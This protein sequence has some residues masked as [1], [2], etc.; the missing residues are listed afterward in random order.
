MTTY[1]WSRQSTRPCGIALVG[2]ADQDRQVQVVEDK[3]NSGFP[4]LHDGEPADKGDQRER[5]VSSC[6][7]PVKAE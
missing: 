6:E 1:A 4:V 5:P 3:R 2:E 7:G